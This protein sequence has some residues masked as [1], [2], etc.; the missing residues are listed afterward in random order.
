MFA[1]WKSPRLRFEFSA[2]RQP[3]NLQGSVSSSPRLPSNVREF[4]E[5]R[6]TTKDAHEVQTAKEREALAIKLQRRTQLKGKIDNILHN[7]LKVNILI[8][9]S[10]NFS[11]STDILLDIF[12]LTCCRN[13]ERL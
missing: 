6:K 4:T 8:V 12:A 1:F 3:H 13:W 5:M 2:Y 7:L 10:I 11:D 9:N